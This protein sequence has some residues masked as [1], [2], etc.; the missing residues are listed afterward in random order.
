MTP[1]QITGST[2][3]GGLLRGVLA[4]AVA[5]LVVYG[6]LFLTSSEQTATAQA[7]CEQGAAVPDPS[8]NPGLVRDCAILLAA[9]DTLRGTATLDW[10]AST[11][12]A[13][14]TGITL[15][16]TPPRVSGWS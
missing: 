2:F 10:S 3:R 16:G 9:K 15:A 1:A 14:W 8:N 4:G 7:P 12:V 6:V 5:L 11:A 13:D